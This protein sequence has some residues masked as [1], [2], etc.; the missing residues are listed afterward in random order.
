MCTPCCFA[1][2]GSC[3]TVTVPISRTDPSG[4]VL[5]SYVALKDKAAVGYKVMVSSNLL[6]WADATPNITSTSAVPIADTDYEN[7][8][9][10]YTPP[11]TQEEA[12]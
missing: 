7:V 2:A 6:G 9:V 4:P 12:A 3:C 10:T 1:A 11:T 8:T 5:L